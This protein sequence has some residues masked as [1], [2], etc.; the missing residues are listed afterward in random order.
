MLKYK[1]K[2]I[3][4]KKVKEGYALYRGHSER[5]GGRAIRYLG[6]MNILG[7]ATEEKG[8][9]TP[10]SPVR[11]GVKVLRLGLYAVSWP[12]CQKLLRYYCQ[13]KMAWE[14]M[15]AH[16]L[17]RVEWLDTPDGYRRKFPANG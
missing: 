1:S 9:I 17:L 5:V 7:I 2:G 10:T 16:A 12:I 6:A 11:P 14:L 15:Y 3:Y 13:Q 8:L 4:V